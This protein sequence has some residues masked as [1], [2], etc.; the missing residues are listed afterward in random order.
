[1]L[2]HPFQ[3]VPKSLEEARGVDFQKSGADI[4][5][6]IKQQQAANKAYEAQA[7]T[8]SDEELAQTLRLHAFLASEVTFESPGAGI[9]MTP[10]DK[11]PQTSGA[12]KMARGGFVDISGSQPEGNKII[13]YLKAETANVAKEGDLIWSRR[14]LEHGTSLEGIKTVDD[15]VTRLAAATGLELYADPRYG[16]LPV[17]LIGDLKKPAAAGDMMTCWAWG[18]AGRPCRSRYRGGPPGWPRRAKRRKD[19]WRRRTG[20]M[21]CPSCKA[22]SGQFRPAAWRTNAG[23]PAGDDAKRAGGEIFDLV[24]GYSPDSLADTLDRLGTF[25]KKPTA[26]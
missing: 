9:S 5:A 25:L 14:D 12:Y 2:P 22:T 8:V 7:R 6:L 19:I 26:P 23:G 1:M 3:I 24:T 15:L 11:R 20:F 17:L 21:P 4:N 16:A 10:G 18:H 13:S